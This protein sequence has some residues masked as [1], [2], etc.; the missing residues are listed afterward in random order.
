MN[1]RTIITGSL[2]LLAGCFV[3]ASLL[4]IYRVDPAIHSKGKTYRTFAITSFSSADDFRAYLLEANALRAFSE[5]GVSSLMGK[6]APTT[7]MAPASS[8]ATSAQDSG[9]TSVFTGRVSATNTQVLGID[10]PDILKTD[11]TNLFYSPESGPVYEPL[12]DQGYS[13]KS[14]PSIIQGSGG[15]VSSGAVGGSGVAIDPIKTFPI[16]N[17]A[18]QTHIIAAQ[19]ATAPALKSSIDSSG[20]L[21]LSGKKLV[22]FTNSGI[23]GFDTSDAQH[24]T[25][26]WSQTYATNTYLVQARLV[27]DRIYAITAS[28]LDR[29]TPCPIRPFSS[30]SFEISCGAIYRPTTVVPVDVTYQIMRINPQTGAIE[31]STSFA[32][33]VD[34]GTVYVSDSAAYVATYNPGDQAA[35]TLSAL[36]NTNSLLPTT[37]RNSLTRLQGYVLSSQA[38]Q[39]EI[40]SVINS[41]ESGLSSDE[42]AAFQIKLAGATKEYLQEHRRELDMTGIVKIALPDLAVSATRSVPGQLLNQF[43]LDEFEGNLRVATT[44]G[45]TGFSY[46]GPDDAAV[47]NDIT[48][49]D[50]HLMVKGQVQ[51]IDSGERL[52]AVRFSGKRGYLVTFKQTD[53]FSILDLSNPAHPEV[54]GSITLPGFSTYL[55]ELTPELVLGVGQDNASPKISLFKV[56][57]PHQPALVSTASL[58]GYWSEVGNDPHAFL[59][60]PD[61]KVVVIPQEQTAE[62]YSYADD[63]LRLVA[64][65]SD[66][67]HRSAYIGDNLYLIGDK[68]V[69]VLDETTWKEVGSAV[70]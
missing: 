43:S 7:M 14:L 21:L 25:A 12:L 33:S 5:G 23:Q 69:H 44:V 38:K 50:S 24:P 65:V 54:S 6:G 34:Q 48:I 49:L 26:V 37:V 17:K 64:K 47:T 30:A 56:S 29:A 40:E 39:I 62:V 36:L 2:I 55:H 18:P 57:D 60:D 45:S 52:F 15:A 41:Y 59:Q 4:T 31:A 3:F 53:P 68:G 51:D 16:P 22:S 1:R 46:R 8:G 19:P 42:Q 61:H 63:T 27:K 20:P 35:F 70:F 9:S 11:G 32:G 67:V 28:N 10:E 58:S 66:S 13:P